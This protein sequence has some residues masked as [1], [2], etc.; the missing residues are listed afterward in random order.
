M[1]KC[2][3]QKWEA[4][5]RSDGGAGVSAIGRGIGRLRVL[6]RGREGGGECSPRI[7]TTAAGGVSSYVLVCVRA[8]AVCVCACCVRC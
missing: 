3:G 4:Y 6:N 8:R 1:D 7:A 2:A 5:A